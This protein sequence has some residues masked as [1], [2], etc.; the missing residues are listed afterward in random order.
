MSKE[1]DDLKALAS[2]FEDEK[3]SLDEK[4][5]RAE[6]LQ[7]LEDK[8]GLP[9]QLTVMTAF[10]ELLACFA[11][12]GQVKNYYR[13]GTYTNCEDQREKF[14]F[15][16]GNGMYSELPRKVSEM[17]LKQLERKLK[18]HEFYVKRLEKTRKRGSCEDVWKLRHEN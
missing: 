9:Q 12:G 15:A 5:Q 10:D 1:E 2:L 8:I 4:R 7:I 13:Y 3:G 17:D 16:L 18:I 11:I 6:Q 14:W